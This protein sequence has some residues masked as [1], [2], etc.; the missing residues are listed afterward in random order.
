M[1]FTSIFHVSLFCGFA[2]HIL[3]QGLV[4]ESKVLFNLEMVYHDLHH[5]TA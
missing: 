4:T 3:D 1:L 2:V 5:S